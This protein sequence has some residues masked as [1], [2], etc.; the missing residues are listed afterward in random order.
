MKFEQTNNLERFMIAY[1]KSQR[2]NAKE[3]YFYFE[4]DKPYVSDD[5]LDASLYDTKEEAQ[6][7]LDKLNDSRAYITTFSMDIFEIC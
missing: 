3:Y 1:K 7:R 5:S 6:E 2:S 4:G